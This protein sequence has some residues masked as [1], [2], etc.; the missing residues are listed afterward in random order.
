MIPVGYSRPDASGH[1]HRVTSDA[2]GVG[3]APLDPSMRQM[4]PSQVVATSKPAAGCQD[5]TVWSLYLD[6][7][8]VL[9]L[10]NNTAD[11][12]I[13]IDEA[14]QSRLKPDLKAFSLFAEANSEKLCYEGTA[15]VR[16]LS[17]RLRTNL[18]YK[19]P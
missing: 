7:L 10:H 2:S 9:G 4:L 13:P 19:R 8:T 14:F 5:H 12:A 18:G 1:H 6:A 11:G 16:R 3:Q 15:P 17:Q